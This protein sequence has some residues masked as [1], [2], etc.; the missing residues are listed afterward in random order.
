MINSTHGFRPYDLTSFMSYLAE[1]L[2]VAM[3][4][5]QDP[6][7][8]WESR[9]TECTATSAKVW[10]CLVLFKIC[11]CGRTRLGNCMCVNSPAAHGGSW[12]A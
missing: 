11:G 7:L 4:I 1:L 3:A 6:T 12:F 2:E 5:L 8:G 10:S 9:A